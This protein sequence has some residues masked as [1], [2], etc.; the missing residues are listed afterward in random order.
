MADYY[1]YTDFRGLY[2]ILISKIM[3]LS[4]D[5]KYGGGLY[6]TDLEPDTPDAHL[7]KSLYDVPSIVQDGDNRRRN[8]RFYIKLKIN[9]K[10]VEKA[11]NNSSG[12]FREHQF[13]YEKGSKGKIVITEIGERHIIKNNRIEVLVWRQDYFDEIVKKLNQ[14]G[15]EIDIQLEEF[16]AEKI[17]QDYDEIVEGFLAET[18]FDKI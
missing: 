18:D 2:S 12:R 5:G 8:L 4:H 7:L 1:H 6:L 15:R 14:R 3:I 10:S 16:E 13:L 11:K 9:S 17:Y